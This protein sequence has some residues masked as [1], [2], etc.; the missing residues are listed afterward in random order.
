VTLGRLRLHYDWSGE[1]SLFDLEADP[2]ERQNIYDP[3]RPEVIEMWSLLEPAVR[4]VE[5][6]YGYTAVDVGP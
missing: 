6:A 5:A 4:Q 2:L 1:K 3:D